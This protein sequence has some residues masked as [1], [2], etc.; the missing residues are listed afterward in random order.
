MLNGLVGMSLD[1]LETALM[2]IGKNMGTENIQWWK[3]DFK[4]KIPARDCL[5]LVE[6]ELCCNG[7]MVESE[8]PQ[9]E[10]EILQEK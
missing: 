1:K 2:E 7:Y 10:I 4:Q 5:S 8:V 6:F 3:A 9:K